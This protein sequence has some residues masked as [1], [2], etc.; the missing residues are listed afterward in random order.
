VGA[1]FSAFIQTSSGAHPASYTVGTGA[2][3]GIKAAAAREMTTHLAPRLK[4]EYSYTSAPS[5]GLHG[6]F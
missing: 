2:F 3:P 1:R 4:E 6:L 5:L